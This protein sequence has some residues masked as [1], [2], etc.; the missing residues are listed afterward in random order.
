MLEG[1]VERIVVENSYADVP[2]GILVVRGENVML[3]GEVDSLKEAQVSSLLTRVTESDIKRAMA[4][5]K[6]DID[7][8]KRRDRLE[9]P[10]LEDY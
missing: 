8:F 7:A 5:R 6:D 2:V 1:T 3:L 9:W 4:A 10:I